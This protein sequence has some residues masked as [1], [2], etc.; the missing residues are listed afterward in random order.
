M[1]MTSPTPEG[2]DEKSKQRGK[3]RLF[4]LTPIVTV[5]PETSAQC[6]FLVPAVC[7][8]SHVPRTA[9]NDRHTS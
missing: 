8:D 7:C 1:M 9:P 3:P 4:P 5:S 2:P 6:S